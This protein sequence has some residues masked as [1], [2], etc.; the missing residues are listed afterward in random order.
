MLYDLHAHV[1]LLILRHHMQV[2]NRKHPLFNGDSFNSITDND[3]DDVVVKLKLMT[4]DADDVDSL[5][6][7]VRDIVVLLQRGQGHVQSISSSCGRSSSIP[8]PDARV[9]PICHHGGSSSTVLGVRAT[10]VGCVFHR[11]SITSSLGQIE[12]VL[13]ISVL[14]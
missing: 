11:D 10:G 8:T 6:H 2:R 4:F 3:E 9:S 12:S 5:L 14:S 13:R 1:E 7:F